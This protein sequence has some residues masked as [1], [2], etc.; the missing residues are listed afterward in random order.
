MIVGAVVQG[1]TYSNAVMSLN[2]AAYW[3][4]TETV[5]PSGGLYVATNSGTLGAAGQGYY[6]TWWQTNGVSDALVGSSSIGHIAGAIAGDTDTAMQQGLVGQYVVIPRVTNGVVDSAVTLTAP[7]SIE[8]WI[9]PTNTAA[10]QLKPIFA[11]GFNNV[12][13]TNAGYQTVLEGA[14]IG[15]Y[16]TEVYFN[17]FNGSASG[18]TEIDTANLAMNTWYHIVATFD[19]TTMSLYT[20]GVLKGTATPP[21]NAFGQNYVPDLVS[22]IIV[23]GG[24]ELGISGGANSFFGS[25]IDEVAIYNAALT[26]NQV[27][28]HYRVA[29]N[30]APV[31]PYSSIVKADSPKI[32][33]RLDE[34]AFAGAGAA[35]T[36]PTAN[37]VGTLAAAANGYYLPGAA[38]G[39]AGPAYSGFPSPSY[40]VALNG[41]NAGVDVGGGSLPA[42]LNPTTNLPVTIAA[43]FKGNPADCVGRF[44]T[45]V[46]HSDASWRLNLD[47]NAGVQFNPGNGPQLQF[48]SVNEELL[49][50]FFVNDGNWHFVAGVCDGTNDSLYIDGLL[51][52]SGT[53]V[54]AVAGSPFDII[55]GGDPQY[56]APQP[57]PI[58][59]GGRC[60]DGSLA[61]VAIFT[62]ALTSSQING[63]YLAAGVPPS[64]RVQPASQAVDAGSIASISAVI[65]GTTNFQWYYNGAPASGQTTSSLT[66]N[67][68]V[69]GSAGNYYV[70]ATNNYGA[71]TSAVV[72][73]T[74]F[75]PNTYAYA[76]EQLNPVAYWPLNETT[77]PP[78]GQYIATNYGTL[79]AAGQGY[80]QSW[81]QPLSFGATNTF[82]ATNCIVHVPGATGDNDKGMWCAN[83]SGSG[84]YVVIP[85]RTNGVVNQAVTITAPFSIEAWIMTTNLTASSRGIVTE[86]RCQNQGDVT[87]SYTNN[88]Q[89]FSLGQYHNYFAF[90]VYSGN[91]ANNTGNQELDMNNL[92]TNVWYH[93]VV[94]YNGSTETMYSNGVS[95]QALNNSFVP[96]MVSPLIIGTGYE[97][98]A[99]TGAG[100]F[101]GGIDDVAIYNTALSQSQIQAHYNAVGSGYSSAV[102]ADSPM[103]YLRLDEPAFNNYPSP[104]SYPVATNYG[105]IGAAANGVYQ[106]GTTP[107]VAG[108]S[109][110]GFG[111]NSAV[112]IN[113]FYGGVDVGGGNLPV[114]LNPTAAQPLTVAAWFQGNPVDARYQEIVSHGDTSWRLALNGNNGNPSTAPFDNEFN[115]GNNPQVGIT[116]LATLIASNFLFNDGNW[117]QAVG[118]SDGTNASIY[119]DGALA[120][121]TNGVGSLAGSGLDVILGGSPSHMTPSYN[122]PSLRFF[123]GN[124]AQV[125]YFTN[126]LTMA[127]VQQLY[128]AAGVPLTLEQQPQSVTNNTG[129]TATLSVLV[130]GSSP[131]YQW[132]T[133]NVNTD[134]IAPVVGQTNASLVFSP[135]NLSNAAYYFVVATNAYNSVTS[136]VAQLTV[137]GPP[138]VLQQTPTDVQVFL[139]TAPTLQQTMAGPTPW[140]FQWSLNGSPITGATNVAYNPPTSVLSTNV[141]SCV[142]TNLYGSVTNS[143]INVAV[144]ADPTAP[145]PVQVLADSPIAYYRLD[146]TSG[147]T[148]YDYAGA[149]N[150]T[151]FNATLGKP[152]YTSGNPV[153]SDPTE[154]APEFGD[155]PPND[156]AGDVPSY[157]NFGTT[158]GGNAEFSVEAWFQEDLYVSGN[159]IVALGYG[160]GG[161]QF[162]LDTGN[163]SAGG[164]RFL[165]RNAAGTSI[166]AGSTYTPKTT[167][168]W[169]HAVGVCD[170]AGGHIYLYMD[171]ALM[172]SNSITAGSGLLSSTMPLSIGARESANNNP[173]NYDYQFYGDIDDVAIYNKA[174]TAA[175]VQAHYFQS[176]VAPTITQLLPSTLTTNA[177]AN[178]SF[179]V[180]AIGSAPLSYQW[181]DNNGNP[182]AWGTNATLNLTNVQTSQSGNY[183]VNVNNF[184]GGPQ[185]TNAVLT[186][187]QVP[188][189]I[190][191]IQP[192]NLSVYA[193]SPVT[194]TVTAF[195][196]PTLTY[197]WYQNGIA[198]PNATNTT[199]TFDALLGS[200]TYYLAVANSY[201]AGNPTLSSTATITGMPSTSLTPANYTDH[202]QITFAGYN[203]SE[204]LSDFPVL[205]RLSTNLTGF[206]YSHFISTA[207]ADLR[208]TDSSGTRIIPHEI[209]EWNPGG[210]STV[211]VQVPELSGTNSTIWAY[212]GNPTPD[213]DLPSTNVWVPQ[214]W[215][216]LPAFDV[217][218][219]LKET[220]FPFA[221][222]CG[223]F[224][225]LAGSAPTP[226]TGVVDT[227]EHFSTSYLDA[228]VIN[229]GNT[230][231]LSAWVNTAT[232]ATSNQAIW[233]S[234]AGS[235]SNGFALFVNTYTTTDQ[236][237]LFET[238]NGS[239]YPTYTNTPAGD[240]SSN[241]WHQ[242][243]AVINRAAATARLFVDGTAIQS[244]GSVRSDF[245]T[246][247]D[248]YLGEFKGNSFPFNGSMDEAR[249]QSGTN[250]DNWVWASYMTV[251]Q[252]ASLQQ[253]SKVNSTI[254][255]PVYIQFQLSGNSLVLTGT[256]GVTNA[257]YY[258]VGTTNLTIPMPQWTVLATNTFDGSGS[259]STSVPVNLTNQAEF[260]GLKLH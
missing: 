106:P 68:V 4:L 190:S 253:Y 122:T 43:W 230:F 182:I 51:A 185:S 221:D 228:G 48:G 76:V 116:N 154:T 178:V 97:L 141:Y 127:Q 56:L 161:E 16:G 147:T 82:Y 205:V 8:V 213:A 29:T 137:F 156:Y 41:F 2:P 247:E 259:F 72:Q 231:T 181:N 33:L 257:V 11:E 173:I 249:I 102:L 88:I 69:T 60:F 126:A 138:V 256:G 244:A 254:P 18:K 47:A 104:S 229:V 90:G 170:E 203:R 57:T 7:F 44:Q 74:V 157:L 30:T 234:K 145:F 46:G 180:T 58:S 189:I 223:Q 55:L 108:P 235:A 212:W 194:L 42:A 85:R 117:H 187:T 92:V 121:K 179:T 63:L 86:G 227:G 206:N 152:G 125:A 129:T 70:V 94:T 96:D 214:S 188:L 160:N 89:G 237:V 233:A 53:F 75:Q 91:T 66:F 175:Q 155:N 139:G 144:I 59:G 195:G 200:N 118:V 105:S 39:A 176:G 248:I 135:V 113:G 246:N 111:T 148:A 159:C 255:S 20:N 38:P 240:V 71:V 172:A 236:R 65:V 242:V 52:K 258:L 95:I 103:I 107:G 202:L 215:E 3:P 124:I 14:S 211:W 34:P 64:I 67:P 245:N 112:A 93:V 32:Y 251:A 31:T 6:E 130:R 220:T 50:G 27:T 9:Y 134:V 5:Q 99:S 133:T 81:Y 164:L 26:V 142:V 19:G 12:Q 219:H 162:D 28:N 166:S 163:G 150:A 120:Y 225:A 171:G 239:A 174:L 84:Q 149:N 222:S 260:L 17:T 224:P 198:I 123:D 146:E 143:P 40:A 73:V 132:Y 216:G 13:A 232:N 62:N 49:N 168:L 22:P 15:M 192:S 109:Y 169:H 177:N 217:V 191:D 23:G 196:T 101:S 193:S 78:A 77:Q 238:A 61:H 80:Y 10:S 1:Q 186:V 243:V 21:K 210:E 153:Q 114:Q 98:S 252:N 167:A 209:D 131:I 83:A 110:A 201:S 165:V 250:S 241:Q 151:Y 158:N 184:Y 208:F 199:Y 204:T 128:S 183:T 119:L 218:Y 36:Y 79:G 136:S 207:G 45:L 25:G 100:E 35:S 197:Q 140:T 54:G 87:R 24:N 226:T 115:P 37:N